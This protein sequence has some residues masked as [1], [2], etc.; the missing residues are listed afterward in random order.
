M[1]RTCTT[2]KTSRIDI[3]G[4]NG[5]EG[6]HYMSEHEEQI[7][8]DLLDLIEKWDFNAKVD[9]DATDRA[10]AFLFRKGWTR[11]KLTGQWSKI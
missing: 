4:S 8:V 1:K 6:E 2:V 5:N 11:D 9:L 7:I 3:I 10:E